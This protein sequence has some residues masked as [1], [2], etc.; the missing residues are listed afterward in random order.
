M[1]GK[2]LLS[3]AEQLHP[4]T[5]GQIV[6]ALGCPR[7]VAYAWKSGERQPP[8][9]QQAHWLARLRAARLRAMTSLVEH[10]GRG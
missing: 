3:F 7:S 1:R 10:V 2:K 8:R 5:A 9:W 6:E 4:W